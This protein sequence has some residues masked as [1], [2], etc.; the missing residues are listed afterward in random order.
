[1][2]AGD[3]RGPAH[4]APSSRAVPRAVPV[5]PAPRDGGPAPLRHLARACGVSTSFLDAFGRRRVADPDVLVAV[6]GA[7]GVP[8]RDVASA[9]QALA[10]VRARAGATPMPPVLVSFGGEP[11]RIRL[12]LPEAVRGAT[13]RV[14][15]T[16]RPGEPDEPGEPVEVDVPRPQGA[17]RVFD[18]P[19]PGTYGVFELNLEVGSWRAAS[20]LIAAP[21]RVPVEPTRT[22]GVF[23]PLHALRTARDDGVGDYTA[24]GEL[25]RWAGVHGAGLLGTLPLLAPNAIADASPYTPSSRRLFSEL[26]VDLAASPE[27]ARS[28]EARALLASDE[29]RDALRRARRGALVD[30]AAVAVRKRRVLDALCRALP[31]AGPR[32][33]AFD[34]FCRAR[35][36]VFDYARF[37]AVGEARGTPW[38]CWPEPLRGGTIRDGDF[39]PRVAQR[40]AYAQWLAA[41]QL[42][43]AARTARESGVRLY[44]DLPVGVHP[45]G[46]DH[47]RG[48]HLFLDG[49]SIG[50]PPDQ[51]FPGGQ[52]WGMAP[53][54]P[55]ALRAGGYRDFAECLRRHF[56][57]APWLRIDHVMA[58]WRLYV[59]PRGER[60]DRGVYLHYRS[61][62]F[63]AV[64][65]LEAGRSG[66]VVVGEDLG[67]VPERVRAE[68]ERHGVQRMYVLPFEIRPEADPPVREPDANQIASLGT[69]DTPTFAAFLAGDDLQGA[70]DEGRQARARVRQTL[71]HFL[72]TRGLLD[73]DD[74][75]AAML[76]AALAF[77]AESPARAVLVNLEDLWFEREPQNVPGTGPE[78]PNWRRR[79][80]HALEDFDRVPVADALALLA[81]ARPRA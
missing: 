30:H 23:L 45:D 16:P 21:R 1:M 34:A 61:E 5:S 13:L 65:C 37:A 15:F 81:R 19:V 35:P 20:T 43:A 70:D 77:L 7:L 46:F 14:V 24:L 71:L 60:A 54:D 68:L 3:L 69:H 10:E 53:P 25:A 63:L 27:L 28:V 72:R 12:R 22:W 44:L 76:R 40:H 64:A 17:R 47:W 73:E 29:F 4:A 41:E 38:R 39:D 31:D 18:V 66:G 48:Q 52:N 33:A 59:V 67:T 49:L 80:R 11:V 74:S 50:A 36:E 58:F 32:R 42:A 2:P 62:E 56:A 79:A 8:L 78:R 6:L 55:R 51:F 26:F 57:V 9:P 75:P